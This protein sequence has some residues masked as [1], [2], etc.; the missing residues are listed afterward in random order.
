M[1]ELASHLTRTGQTQL[2]FARKIG[3]DQATVSRLV[4]RA[5]RPSLDLAVLIERETDG[6]VPAASWATPRAEQGAA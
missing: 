3:V 5:A 2:A 4:R 1:S 6:E